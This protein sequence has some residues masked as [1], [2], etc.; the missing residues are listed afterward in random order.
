MCA[1][2]SGRIAKSGGE[3]LDDEKRGLMAPRA[4]IASLAGMF[5]VAK[6]GERVNFELV[7]ARFQSLISIDNSARKHENAM[8]VATVYTL[9][10]IATGGGSREA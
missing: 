8:K 10:L 1:G 4:E 9:G 6:L 2:F 5:L 7:P 3:F